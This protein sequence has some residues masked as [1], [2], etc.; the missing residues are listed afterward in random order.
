[1]TQE[2]RSPF[3]AVS[4][5]DAKT[6]A[7]GVWGPEFVVLQVCVFLRVSAPDSAA[8]SGPPAKAGPDFRE[9]LGERGA[10][11]LPAV[12]ARRHPVLGGGRRGLGRGGWS[13]AGAPARSGSRPPRLPA[14]RSSGAALRFPRGPSRIAAGAQD[15]GGGGVVVAWQ[16][17][18]SASP[19]ARPLSVAAARA[20]LATPIR[21]SWEPTRRAHLASWGEA[22]AGVRGA[23]GAR[24]GGAAGARGGGTP[25]GGGCRS[26]GGTRGPRGRGTPG[27]GARLLER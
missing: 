8:A 26:G 13:S 27:R 20:D 16:R 14:R 18:G 11:L 24:G 4:C 15:F 9:D 17:Q 6:A 3:Q 19:S 7:W 2:D 21:A 10:R 22:A 1:M 5:T 23:A 25:A 12:P